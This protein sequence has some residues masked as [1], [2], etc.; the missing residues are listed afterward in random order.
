MKKL[1]FVRGFSLSNDPEY[2]EYKQIQTFFMNSKY[3]LE[4]FSY[5]TEERLD[6]VYKR[7]EKTI[8]T[9]NYSV[10]MGHS[11][12]GAL[13][14]KYCR[15]NDI[16]KYEKIILLMPFIRT[17]PFLD[18][19]LTWDFSREWRIPKAMIA[20]QSFI[21]GVKTNVFS[22]FVSTLLNDSFSP[23]GIHQPF[24]SKDNLFLSDKQMIRLFKRNVY[25]IHSPTDSLVSFEPELLS[26]IKNQY[27]VTGGHLSF[28]SKK[29]EDNFFDILLSVLRL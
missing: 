19:L 3:K 24:Y 9:V 16:S 29:Y 6:E 12:G 7:L 18:N 28:S 4:Y 23:I 21:E 27:S 14:S 25:L 11:M 8:Q 22:H 1:L 20:P 15:E 13:L 26:R 2:D 17:I 5:T 10:L